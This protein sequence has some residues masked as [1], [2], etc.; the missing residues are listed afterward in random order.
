MRRARTID[1]LNAA[2]VS[3]S[4]QGSADEKI[5][6]LSSIETY[7]NT[8]NMGSL[9]PGEGPLPAHLLPVSIGRHFD[10]AALAE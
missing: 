5:I 6:P 10:P 4:T 2:I 9:I 3:L 8:R 1:P 7:L